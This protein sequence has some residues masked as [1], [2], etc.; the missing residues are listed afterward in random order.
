MCDRWDWCIVVLGWLAIGLVHFPPLKRLQP[1]KAWLVLSCARRPYFP[2]SGGVVV[3]T[4]LI[5]N[6]AHSRTMGTTGW[7]DHDDDERKCD[8]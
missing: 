2:L 8:I 4:N 6:H 5:I 1:D 7:F 3:T